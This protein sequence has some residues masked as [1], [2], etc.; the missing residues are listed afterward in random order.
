MIYDSKFTNFEKKFISH[1]FTYAFWKYPILSVFLYRNSF[2]FQPNIKL[3]PFFDFSKG[4]LSPSTGEFWKK[5]WIR[6]KSACACWAWCSDH[7]YCYGVQLCNSCTRIQSVSALFLL[8][9]MIVCANLLIR[10]DCHIDFVASTVSTNI[11]TH[12]LLRTKLVDLVN[13]I[14]SPLCVQS[15][16][17]VIPLCSKTQ[18]ALSINP[19]SVS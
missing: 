11:G 4:L 12:A 7:R 10:S 6:D 8:H 3:N 9:F 15:I 1:R 17:N 14:L 18:F 5:C 2:T 19:M 13:V 16:S